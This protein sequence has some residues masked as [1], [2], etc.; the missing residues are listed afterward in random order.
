MD[1]SLVAHD[2]RT[3]LNAMLGHTHLLAVEK[4]SAAG[5]RRLEIIELQIR[6]MTTLLDR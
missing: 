1:F 4:L 5:R 6:R 2:L 3:P